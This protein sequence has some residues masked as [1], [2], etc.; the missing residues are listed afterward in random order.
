MLV[1][2]SPRSLL[3]TSAWLFAGSVLLAPAVSGQSVRPLFELFG[4]F[5]RP[6]LA[7]SVAEAYAPSGGVQA[8]GG[9][10]AAVGAM[11]GR[12]EVAGFYELGTASV[13]RRVAP[14]RPTDFTR[15]TGGLRVELPLPELGAEFRGLISASLFVQTLDSVLVS[16]DG[17]GGFRAASQRLAPGGRFEVGVEHRGFVGTTLFVTGGVA[18]AGAGSGR[19]Q[20]LTP[21]RG[22]IGVAPIVTIGL[23]TREW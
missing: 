6:A 8:G 4:T 22:G 1:S 10:G 13:A 3:R 16:P 19:W 5:G 18:A 17:A 21:R 2:H 11:I 20:N 12:F 9:V 23:R 15:S 7:P 14:G